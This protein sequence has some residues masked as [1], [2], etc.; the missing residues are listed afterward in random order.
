MN[1]ERDNGPGHHDGFGVASSAPSPHSGVYLSSAA[2]EALCVSALRAFE[3]TTELPS[4]L[5]KSLV[6]SLDVPRPARRPAFRRASPVVSPPGGLATLVPVPQPS[7]ARSS[8]PLHA[9]GSIRAASACAAV[10]V[11]MAS[12]C[13]TAPVDRA[14]HEAGQP[15]MHPS[16]P[17]APTPAPSD[18]FSRGV[19]APELSAKL[20]P[21]AV[22]NFEAGRENPGGEPET[23]KTSVARPS[24][25]RLLAAPLEVEHGEVDREAPSSPAPALDAV[26]PAKTVD[27]AHLLDTARTAYAQGS[28]AR[29][30][31]ALQTC[32]PACQKGPLA[33]DTMALKV[34]A[35]AANGNSITAATLGTRFLQ[36]YPNSPHV[37]TILRI[38][39]SGGF[40]GPDGNGNST[41]A[42]NGET[43]PSTRVYYGRPAR[44]SDPA[45][46]SGSWALLGG[47]EHGARWT[48]NIS[49]VESIES[50]VLV[51][52][53]I[54]DRSGEI[55]AEQMILSYSA[56]GDLLDVSPVDGR[57]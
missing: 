36:V 10:L 54:E 32:G 8:T 33:E 35:L 1:N 19:A 34:Q 31:E 17:N 42:S 30:L 41:V 56:E 57:L 12:Y 9:M 28:P 47:P 5:G 37:S 44:G 46:R 14:R 29:A 18:H 15:P 48:V 16:E 38:V 4:D 22:T 20:R 49:D 50:G 23:S 7:R 53:T 39:G 27:A 51:N 55:Q 6:R 40:S 26:A 2:D 24:P 11:L 52:A 13:P 25:G 21:E 45:E 43:N 3:E